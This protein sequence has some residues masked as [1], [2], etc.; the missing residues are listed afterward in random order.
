[1]PKTTMSTEGRLV[2][3]AEFRELDRLQP[4]EEFTIERL[5]VGDYRLTRKQQS[6]NEG[7]VHWLLACPEKGFFVA[8]DSESTDPS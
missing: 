7:L 8:I 6:P 1:M 3:P 5:G 4:G 2:L